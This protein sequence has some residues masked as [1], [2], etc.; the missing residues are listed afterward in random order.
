MKIMKK[1][2]TTRILIPLALTLLLLLSLAIASIYW[3]QRI[4]LNE[5]MSENLLEVEQLF[6]MKLDEEAKVL[7]SQINLLQMDKA[8]QQAYLAKDRKALLH[9]ALPFFNAIRSKHQVTHF[10][11]IELDQ[12]CFL[13]VHN[14]PRY[15]DTIPRF[16]L[17]G[18]MRDNAPVYGIELGKFATFTLRFVYP[19]RINGELIGYIELG[20]E[21]EHITVALHHILG[22][23]LFFTINKSFIERADWEEGLKMMGRSGNWRQFPDVILID[24]TMPTVPETLK[25]ILNG[26]LDV[27]KTGDLTT[28]FN[29][30]MNQKPYHGGFIPLFDAG[31]RELGNIVVL[32]EVSEQ[33]RA[34]R[35][36][37]LI[38]IILSI[39][40][41]SG[42]LVFFYLFIR[43]IEKQIIRLHEQ[44][45]RTHKNQFKLANEA[46]DEA[47]RITQALDNVNTSVLISDSESKIIYANP[48]AQAL[49]QKAKKRSALKTADFKAHDLLGESLESLLKFSVHE[50]RINPTAPSRTQI[51]LG[52]LKL[53]VNRTPVMNADGEYKG[54][55]AECRDR[56]AEMAT[57][58][59]V[60]AVVSAACCGDFSQ[61]IDLNNKN[62]FFKVFSE[63]LN[64][65]L[66]NIEQLIEELRDVFTAIAQG[67][68][69]R[70]MTREYT[71]SIEQ[72][73][74]EVN[75]TV[76][77]LTAILTEIEISAQASS[78]G[79]FTQPI[80]L[81]DKSG[82]FVSL[83][84]L[85]NQNLAANQQI[86]GELKAL[87]AAMA[88]GDL[89]QSLTH[90][91]TGA[92]EHLKNDINETVETL[93][94]MLNSVKHTFD[95]VNQVSGHISQYNQ[96]LSERTEQQAGNLEET[97]SSMEEMTSTVQQNADNALIANKL[98]T[99]TCEQAEEGRKVVDRAIR[100][101]REINHSSQKVTDIISVIDEIAFQTNLL[102]LNAA[103]EAARAGEQGRGF[104]VVA[105]EVR[106]LAQRSA[107]A[108]K[109]IKGLIQESVNKVEEG[110]DLV[111]HSGA[112]LK[113][114]VSAVKKVSD[115]ISEIAAAS[116]EQSQ[117][118]QQVN[119]VITQLDSMTQQN[120]VLVDEAANTSAILKE[121]VQRLKEQI[122][123]F[124]T[125]NIK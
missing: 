36:L 16:T 79:D 47:L 69:R 71:G 15:G 60:N 84:Q 53:E 109:E 18:A 93:T 42:L 75:A 12:L 50:S 24:K 88:K 111:N 46:K 113:E 104:A 49:F 40:I 66:D 82:F 125:T 85:M 41:G 54:F 20:K 114:I 55:V 27:R 25:E 21:I 48:S 11:F 96:D 31:Q 9:H 83:S 102:A 2:M 44:Q 68:L 61:R 74:Q 56:T 39:V 1:N 107:T 117:G 110:T 115:L 103:V 73:K 26:F 32:K 30:S 51:T 64:Q 65:T 92:F 28:N 101:M 5:E 81:K 124:N 105:Q 98:A 87:F 123:F 10:Y 37:S 72:L 112:T 91:Y 19:W 23:E 34:L 100:A 122:A 29:V 80:Y 4:H 94:E 118:I 45:I 59:E 62:G 86:I 78:Q 57:K 7:E 77:Q 120:A 58:Q 90:H 17:T 43:R 6:K 35:T 108:A 63:G 89:T 121:E 97:A 52:E 33:K 3:L 8:L 76:H 38:L 106:H 70:G 67:D 99:E 116:Q 13:R 95:V 22:V 119:Q 14:P